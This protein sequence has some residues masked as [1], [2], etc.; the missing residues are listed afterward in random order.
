M[1]PRWVH[2]EEFFSNHAPSVVRAV[3]ADCQAAWATT[4]GRPVVVMLISPRM[5]YSLLEWPRM[6]S[7]ALAAG[8]EVVTWKAPGVAS[9]EWS[10]AV[11]TVGWTLSQRA[12]IS[13][14]PTACAAGLHRLNHFPVSSVVLGDQVHDWPIWGVLTDDAWAASLALRL[15][16][17]KKAVVLPEATSP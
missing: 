14:V 15:D 16:I 11:Q 12:L 8:F 17:L 1:A 10:Q 2:A 4:S 5:V 9:S 3:H 6:R 13:D 7:R